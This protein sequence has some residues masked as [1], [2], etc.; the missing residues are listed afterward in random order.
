M[1]VS[2]ATIRLCVCRAREVWR[3]EMT[4]RKKRWSQKRGDVGTLA[5]SAKFPRVIPRMP[6]PTPSATRSKSLFLV[7][8]KSWCLLLREPLR[9]VTAL[10]LSSA[11]SPSLA[12]RTLPKNLKMERKLIQEVSSC[13]SVPTCGRQT[14]AVH[15]HEHS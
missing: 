10:E 12:F 15:E 13:L 14:R 5:S 7:L 1:L 4:P 9:V 8:Y 6:P 11:S 3:E 2:P